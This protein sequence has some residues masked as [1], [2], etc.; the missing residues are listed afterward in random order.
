MK[1][2]RSILMLSTTAKSYI[3]ASVPVLRDHGLAI[4]RTFYSNM[5]SE[6]PELRNLFN[7]GNQANGAQQQSLAAALFAYAA[8]IENANALQPVIERIAHKHASVGIKA[9]HYPI[10]GEHLI[11]AIQVVLGDAATQELLDAWKEAYTLLADTLIAAE[12]ALYANQTADSWL[13][14][15]VTAVNPHPGGMTSYTL[16]N[17]NGATLPT[18]LPGQYI[19]VACYIPALQ[20]RQIRQ[21]SLSDAPDKNSYRI[22][23]KAEE[24]SAM[25]PAGTVSNWMAEHIKPGSTLKISAPYGNFT[26]NVM[27]DEPLHLISAGIGITPMLS[28]I[29]AIHK[30]NPERRVVFAH[31]A[32]SLATIPHLDE[33]M[34]MK[35]Q[36]PRLVVG[37]FVKTLDE[38]QPWAH[39]GRLDVKQFSHE[40]DA[41][42]YICGSQKFMDAQ[43]TALTAIGVHADKIQREMFGPESLSHLL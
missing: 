6:H 30:T 22:T 41:N 14:V 35:T 19:S 16:K 33:I 24:A 23:V 11:N 12:K 37:L 7:M 31:A 13:D 15:T 4:T 8:N 38:P 26:A 21:Y 36:M 2:K 9:E 40:Q 20:L 43:H 34:Q 29:K 32:K 27:E 10:V 39:I 3:E 28:I 17:T 18:F 25:K 42:Y 1:L 5:F